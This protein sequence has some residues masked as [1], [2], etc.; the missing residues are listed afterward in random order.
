MKSN[1]EY[2]IGDTVKITTAACNN[3]THDWW[4]PSNTLRSDKIGKTYIITAVDYSEAGKYG[5]G[6]TIQINETAYGTNGVELRES[7]INADILLNQLD[8]LE[9]GFINGN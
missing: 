9:E 7:V 6:Y 3:T 8:Q 2:E 5:N 1:G 4:V